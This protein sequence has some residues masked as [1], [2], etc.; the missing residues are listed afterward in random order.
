MTVSQPQGRPNTLAGTGRTKKRMSPAVRQGKH[1]TRRIG[2]STRMEIPRSKGRRRGSGTSPKEHCN[3]YSSKEKLD[4]R[5][6]L[7][8]RNGEAPRYQL[9]RDRLAPARA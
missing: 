8:K 3:D 7:S 1:I 2:P 6:H 9:E 5:P 4:A